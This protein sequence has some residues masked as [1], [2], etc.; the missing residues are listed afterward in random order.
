MTEKV[1]FSAFYAIPIGLRILIFGQMGEGSEFKNPAIW[2][3]IL[4]IWLHIRILFSC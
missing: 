2:C 4:A 3:D 1:R